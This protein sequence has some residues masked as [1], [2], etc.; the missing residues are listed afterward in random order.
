MNDRKEKKGGCEIPINTVVRR[1][2][3]HPLKNISTK[4]I[5]MCTD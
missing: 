1:R 2:N 5:C 3:K 4:Y